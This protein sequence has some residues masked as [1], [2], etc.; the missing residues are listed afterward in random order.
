MTKILLLATVLAA[1][2]CA[3]TISISSTCPGFTYGHMTI[4]NCQTNTTFSI[5]EFG[6][7]GGLS[8]SH[9]C[10]FQARTI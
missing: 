10:L 6:F 8:L 3:A 1:R 7:P 4:S 2:L 9:K 5:S